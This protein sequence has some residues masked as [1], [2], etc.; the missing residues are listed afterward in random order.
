MIY[1]VGINDADYPISTIL[2]SKTILCPIYLK[3]KNM[4][5]RCYH[6][7]FQNKNPS[8]IGC[9]VSENWKTF[10]N[11]RSWFIEHSNMDTSLLVDKDLLSVGNKVYCESKCLLVSSMVNMFISGNGNDGE[12][13]LGVSYHKTLG[14][15]Q[16][17]CRNPFTKKREHLGYYT[18]CEE[19]FAHYAWITRKHV[20]SCK[21][22]DEQIDERVA[23]ALRNKYKLGGDLS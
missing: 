16:A 11:F 15:L 2:D 7:P 4:I 1:G 19:K 5:M 20:L 21:L 8:Y 3:W 17:K 14:K 18:L 22:A 12:Y 10:S 9:F 13:L 6:K 23:V